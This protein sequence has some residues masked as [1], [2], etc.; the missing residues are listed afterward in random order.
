MLGLLLL[1][2]GVW[3]WGFARAGGAVGDAAWNA[4]PAGLGTKALVME[5]W[6]ESVPYGALLAAQW[7]VFFLLCLPPVAPRGD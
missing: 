6:M 7:R 4:P 3:A 5:E 2:V 1:A